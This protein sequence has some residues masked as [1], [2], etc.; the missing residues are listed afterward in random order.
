MADE[1][2]GDTGAE[3]KGTDA[4]D[5]ETLSQEAREYMRRKVQS[6]SDAKAAAST[7][8]EMQK[9]RAEQ[10]QSARSAVESAEEKELQQLAESGQHEALGQRVA[11]RLTSRNVEERA[12]GR[13][14]DEIERQMSAA[15]TETLGPEKVEEV[16]QQTIKD[17]G[18]HA[19]YALGLAKAAESKTRADEI[20]AEVKAQ[21]TEART[22]KRDEVTGADKV[23]GAGQGPKPD[24]SNFEAVRA[25][26][27][28]GEVSTEAFEAADK[29]R[30]EQM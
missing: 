16:R 27:G 2:T 1:D 30:K 5:P 18:A 19:E 11:A 13:A 14:S 4:F 28:R 3:E 6:D 12:I 25:A 7:A 21:L 23:T 29:A 24:P 10:A 26:Y 22:G 8:V 9:L 17:G 20:A 15:F